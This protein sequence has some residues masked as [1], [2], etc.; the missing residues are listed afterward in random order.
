MRYS[1]GVGE[2]KNI[3]VSL[4]NVSVKIYLTKRYL[5]S[6]CKEAALPEE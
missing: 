4:R 1:Y 2:E 5:F 3:S 6:G